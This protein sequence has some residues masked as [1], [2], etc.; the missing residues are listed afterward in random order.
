MFFWLSGMEVEIWLTSKL[1]VRFV[2]LHVY[3]TYNLRRRKDWFLSSIV[4]TVGLDLRLS[5]V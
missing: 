1:G 2:L 5:E 4:L 3:L